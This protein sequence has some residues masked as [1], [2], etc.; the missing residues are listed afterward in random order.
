MSTQGGRRQRAIRRRA[1]RAATRASP[2]TARCSTSRRNVRADAA[3]IGRCEWTS[4]RARRSSRPA[5][6]R[7][8][9]DHRRPTRASRSRRRR[10]RGGGGGG[11]GGRGVVAA[12]AGLDRHSIEC[13][14][15]VRDA[16]RRSRVRLTTRSRSRRTPARFDGRQIVRHDRTRPTV[17]RSSSLDRAAAPRRDT[18]RAGADLSRAHRR[19]AQA[20]HEH[21]V[22]APRAR[23]CRRT[24]NGSRS[25]PT[26][27]SAPTRSSTPSAIRSPSC[28]PIASATSCRATIRR[29]S[30]CPVAACEQ[31]TADAR[32]ARSSTPA[33][34]RSSTWSP[35]SKQIAFV[36]QPARFKNQRLFV[37]A[38]DGGK[39]Q[40]IL[41][42]WQYEPGQIQWLKDGQIG[43]ST[44][45]GGSTRHLHDRSG[46]EEDH[47]D[48]R[49]TARQ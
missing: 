35:D 32:R 14:R 26:R 28:R 1:S 33:T 34:S 10:R 15:S 46:H 20:A 6:R 47:D 16:W 19:P 31:Q 49:R 48:P 17:R 3:R 36:G 24:A 4:R 12:G 29:S 9:R 13:Q 44:P 5:H 43:M 2:T 42:T 7:S 18:P 37:V 11:G 40:D 30:S 22:L 8:E 38:A 41:G 27:S 23:S 45:T 21:E 39:P 25:S